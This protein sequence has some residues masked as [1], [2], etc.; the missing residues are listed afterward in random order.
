MWA[1]VLAG[2][3]QRLAERLTERIDPVQSWPQGVTRGVE[4]L[5]WMVAQE[6]L[7]IRVA[8]R[9]HKET[10]APLSF[11]TPQDGYV[12]EKWA[13]FGD[14][15]GNRLYVTGSLNESR[16]A[17]VHNAEN[18]DVHAQWWGAIEQRRIE[19]AQGAF[20]TVWNDQN[21]HL[22]VLSLPDAVRQHL[23]KIGEQ[24][25]V[26]LEVDGSSA[27]RPGVAPP[28]ALERLR[29][30][31]IKDG[32]RLPGG[33]FVG[34][35]TVPFEPWPHQEVVARRLVETWPYNFL[36]CDEVGLG[37]TIEAGMAIRA[38]Y[39]SGL[40]RRVLIAPPASLTRQWQR[41]MASKFC[42]PF[43]RSLTGA[44][45][46][47]EFIFPIAETR[48]A[49]NLYQ[50]DLCIV[51]TGLLSRQERQ[52][53]IQTAATFDIALIDEAHY[54]RRKNPRNGAVPIPVSATFTGPSGIVC[55]SVASVFGWPRPRPCNWTGS[56][57]SISCV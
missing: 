3:A 14:N 37:K 52:I 40:V 54:A 38:L 31:L 35:A 47:H 46:K 23:V 51:S 24:V 19:D 36:L 21:P 7:E 45:V 39:L 8:L 15:D 22:R 11:D 4:L 42:M 34:L 25:K 5:A 44:T 26:P 2:D 41:E 57:P 6:Y 55:K 16:T 28:S 56:R 48:E 49:K 9:V 10:Q 33:R 18:I 1:A 53:E 29:F 17:L 32:P 13:I 27:V 20:E 50:P 30:A 43:A 12:H